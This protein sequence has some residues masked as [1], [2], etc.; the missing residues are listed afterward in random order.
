MW[1]S[2][3]VT[4]V[5]VFFTIGL[6][7]FR[8]LFSS[9]DKQRCLMFAMSAIFASSLQMQTGPVLSWASEIVGLALQRVKPHP[10]VVKAMKVDL[11]RKNEDEVEPY[12]QSDVDS[13]V[14]PEFNVI[15]PEFVEMIKTGS[16][17]L[18]SFAA[19]L[20]A[21]YYGKRLLVVTKNTT[22]N[23]AIVYELFRFLDGDQ[24]VAV[25][26]KPGHFEPL[27][28]AP[29]FDEVASGVGLTYRP[30]T[31][32]TVSLLQSAEH[33]HDVPECGHTQ[34][35][36][37]YHPLA[38]HPS[39]LLQASQRNSSTQATLKVYPSPSGEGGQL[40]S[41]QCLQCP[42]L[43]VEAVDANT[44][45]PRLLSA[46]MASLRG[47]KEQPFPVPLGLLSMQNSPFCEFTGNPSSAVKPAAS[48]NSSQHTSLAAPA[49]PVA[50]AESAASA[51]PVASANSSQHT[52]LAAP[53]NPLTLDSTPVPPSGVGLTFPGDKFTVAS[54]RIPVSNPTTD[55]HHIFDL[56]KATVALVCLDDRVRELLSTVDER[57]Q[58]VVASSWSD[59]CSE[60]NSF[61]NAPIVDAEA[62]FLQFERVSCKYFEII[63]VLEAFQNLRM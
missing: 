63:N 1:H 16:Q 57:V 31:A 18:T 44:K 20:I 12:V 52:S 11:G 39:Q 37:C 51:K 56:N 17:P 45:S 46:K 30:P 32:R 7:S 26:L 49:K 60:C 33:Q 24:C 38:T 5:Q 10:C 62:S 13:C 8:N 21:F 19:A 48:A 41:F 9:G 55:A 43:Y 54:A 6:L 27:I 4:F 47:S 61:I 28:P 29:A 2:Q 53:T 25:Y 14:D 15:A 35:E 59:A 42:A 40:R 22:N 50:S 34:L 36:A 3:S 58:R 23:S